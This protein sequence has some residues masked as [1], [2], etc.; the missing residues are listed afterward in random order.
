MVLTLSRQGKVVPFQPGP[1][2]AE[3]IFLEPSAQGRVSADFHLSLPFTSFH[4]YGHCAVIGYNH[5]GQ[6]VIEMFH[7]MLWGLDIVS[8]F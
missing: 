8:S 2:T 3:L 7:F 5:L 4:I 1:P 6:S